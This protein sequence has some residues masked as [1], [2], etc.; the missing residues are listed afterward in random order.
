MSDCE[1]SLCGPVWTATIS[2]WMNH[3]NIQKRWSIT[4]YTFLP[5]RLSEEEHL[6]TWLH[7]GTIPTLSS[8][9]F[10]CL[11]TSKSNVVYVLLCITLLIC[12][13][14]YITWHNSSFCATMLISWW[15]SQTYFEHH[16][17]SKIFDY[18]HC[19]LSE[20]CGKRML[21]EEC[22]TIATSFS[23]VTSF[24]VNVHPTFHVSTQQIMVPIQKHII[25]TSKCC[26]FQACLS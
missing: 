7:S 3:P 13:Y 4:Y 19:K 18:L 11:Q 9:W 24:H 6:F 16:S 8:C 23:F 12:W 25:D 14:Y 10:Q 5:F 26:A 22:W 2:L 21:N 20:F 17:L 1:L 15:R